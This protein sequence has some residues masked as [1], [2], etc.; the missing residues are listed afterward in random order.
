M[1]TVVAVATTTVVVAVAGAVIAAIAAAATI[2]GNTRER[3]A[4]CTAPLFLWNYARFLAHCLLLLIYM[5]VCV[6]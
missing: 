6:F 5:S 1:A 4:A 2:A 3:G